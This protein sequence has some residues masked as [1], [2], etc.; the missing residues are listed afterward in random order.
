MDLN[1]LNTNILN[2]AL[3]LISPLTGNLDVNSK[4]LTNVG[5]VAFASGGDITAL[6][7][8]AFTDATADASAAGRAR[9]NATKLTWHDGTAA[10]TLLTATGLSRI[11]FVRKTADETVNNSATLQNDDVLLAALVANEVVAFICQIFYS[12][13]GTPDFKFTFTVPALATIVWN[14]TSGIARGTG[15]AVALQ[16]NI[17]ASAG[18]YSIDGFGAPDPVC[19]TVVGTV[20]NGANAGNLQLQWA[21]DV[22]TVADT[23]VLTNSW[24]RVEHV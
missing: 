7:E 6:D 11:E 3:S 13:G 23:K 9:R 14:V 21:Q 10:R 18:P 4:N 12:S 20:V 17:V 19:V 1:A 16:A 2:N 15:G 22:A 8:L 24:L 5:A